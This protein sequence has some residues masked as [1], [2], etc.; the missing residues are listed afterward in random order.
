MHPLILHLSLFKGCIIFIPLP[1]KVTGSYCAVSVLQ[2]C[3]QNLALAHRAPPCAPGRHR[4][5]QNC[6]ARTCPPSCPAPQGSAGDEQHPHQAA[7]QGTGQLSR[8]SLPSESSSQALGGCNLRAQL[9]SAPQEGTQQ[10]TAP[11]VTQELQLG[12][13]EPKALATTHHHWVQTWI[14]VSNSIRSS[15][16]HGL[17]WSLP[18]LLISSSSS[19]TEGRGTAHPSSSSSRGKGGFSAGHHKPQL[20]PSVS[21]F[22]QPPWAPA[23]LLQQQ[24]KQS[25]QLAVPGEQHSPDS[26]HRRC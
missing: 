11:G 2:A 5:H 18:L 25:S 22:V 15:C 17:P 24:Q 23:S 14:F 9:S 1:V 8:P 13:A 4:G 6:P 12:T 19:A 20:F 21:G 16:P 7:P 26:Q 10:G 3:L